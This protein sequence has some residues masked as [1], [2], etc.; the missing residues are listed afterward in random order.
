M[1]LY[2]IQAVKVQLYGE[3]PLQLYY[4]A[5]SI[6]GWFAWK[7]TRKSGPL[8]VTRMSS[9]QWVAVMAGG[10]FLTLAY[11]YFLAH[12]V[13][14]AQAF[15]WDDAPL[16]LPPSAYPYADAFT[17]AF[18]FLATWLQAR[19]KLENWIFWLAID[20]VYV[21][22]WSLRGGYFFALL[23]LLYLLLSVYGYRQWKA[24][25]KE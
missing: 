22:L 6:Y 25:L 20:S 8:P 1:L 18:S 13:E 3:V 4:I 17:T 10:V 16:Y 21:V 7:G 19:K 5:V 2:T 9:R 14:L 11:G 24:S 12:I 23:S 15:G